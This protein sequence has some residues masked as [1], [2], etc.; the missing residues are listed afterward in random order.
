MEK[1]KTPEMKLRGLI[2]EEIG[3]ALSSIPAPNAKNVGIP[4]DN[5]GMQVRY[6]D[7]MQK[8]VNRSPILRGHLYGKDLS[9][10]GN[11][12]QFSNPDTKEGFVKWMLNVLDSKAAMQEGNAGEGG[13]LVP[14]QYEDEIVGFARDKSIFLS[15][16]RVYP[17][18]TDTLRV[19]LEDGAVSVY[20]TDEE[21]ALTESE[22]T[23]GEAAFS[24]VK[25]GAYAI[26]SNELLQ[27]SNVDVVSW[28]TE[29]FTEKLAQKVDY[30]AFYGTDGFDSALSGCGTYSVNASGADT[31][32][33]CDDGSEAISQ[34]DEFQL[35]GAK[36]YLSKEV[37][38][39][40]RTAKN[41]NNSYVFQNPGAGNVPTLWTYPI[42]VSSQLTSPVAAGSDTAFGLF[43]PLAKG[44]GIALRKMG[45]ALEVDPYGRFLQYQTRF[46]IVMRCDGKCLL[47]D[48]LVELKSSS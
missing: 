35:Q 29:L 10:Q 46:R 2:Q 47:D 1:T 31:T 5:S 45:L 3:N 17:T 20:A 44:Y 6:T 23:V 9:K 30:C 19:P 21:D 43:S 39:A 32:F 26:A 13:Y 27:D 42:R 12:L 14:E 8:D 28:L 37:H 11:N 7:H 16:A 18:T 41:S 34:L 22:P 4:A 38:H 48:A 33:D 36:F 25:I 24:I 40:L 15:D